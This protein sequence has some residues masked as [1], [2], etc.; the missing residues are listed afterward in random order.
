M[1]TA[2]DL[3]GRWTLR[4]ATSPGGPATPSGISAAN[5]PRAH[6]ASSGPGNGGASS[7]SGAIDGRRR[8]GVFAGPGADAVPATVPGC[9][10]TDLM[11]AGR[12]I[13]PFLGENE[14][15]VAWVGRADWVYTREIAWTG[16]QHDRVDMVF[17]GV[18]TVADITLDGTPIGST[19]NMHRSYRFDVTGL[20]KKDL[21]VHFS[22]AYTEA[23]RVEA[24]LGPRPNAY[25]E[26]FNFVRKMACSFGWDWGPTLVTAGIWRPVRLEGWSIARLKSVRPLATWADGVGRLDLSVAVER[27]RDRPL[28]ALVL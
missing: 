7:V 10:H 2:E 18:D 16:P 11:A 25:P 13:D 23:A 5:G 3:A 22:S 19:R 14:K 28:T 17:E 26:P 15:A 6:D 4:P 9:V 1:I 20:P 8:S 24:M 27:T 12:L 21:R